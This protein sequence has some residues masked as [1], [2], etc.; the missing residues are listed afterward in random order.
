[1]TFSIIRCQMIEHSNKK[2]PWDF[3]VLVERKIYKKERKVCLSTWK[4]Q[5]IPE[6]VLL[7]DK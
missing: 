6:P 5:M 7:D 2:E 1:M 3:T 4:E